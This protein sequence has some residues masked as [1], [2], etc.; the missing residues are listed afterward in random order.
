MIPPLSEALSQLVQ[1]LTFL[2]PQARVTSIQRFLHMVRIELAFDV[3][4]QFANRNPSL[5]F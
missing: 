1:I 2:V 4:T 5:E 3:P